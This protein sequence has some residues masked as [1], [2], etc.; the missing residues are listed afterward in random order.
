M[1]KAIV[2]LLWLTLAAPVFAQKIPHFDLIELAGAA[3]HSVSSTSEATG[4][5]IYTNSHWEV[6]QDL[7]KKDSDFITLMNSV[8]T[9]GGA[10]NPGKMGRPNMAKLM[11][12][13][14]MNKDSLKNLSP[15]QLM[16][17]SQQFGGVVS[18]QTDG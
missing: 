11:A 1:K 16:Q 4:Y 5:S 8:G 12:L 17:M 14:S 9:E 10:A 18:V 3:P 2:M 7:R 6:R 15:A 13:K